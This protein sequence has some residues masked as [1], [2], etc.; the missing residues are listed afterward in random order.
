MVNR[1]HN[2][3]DLMIGCSGWSYRRWVGPFYPLLSGPEEWLSLY[4]KVFPV[5]EIDSTFYGFPDHETIKRWRSSVSDK[6]KFFPKTPKQIT[7][8]NRS[9]G[10]GVLLNSF[11]ESVSVLGSKLGTV[12]IQFPHSFT[13]TSGKE[14]LKSL[15]EELP[16]G[17]RY[18][19]EFRHNSWFQEYTYSTLRN[20]EVA[21]VWSEIPYAKVPAA[22]TTDMI[23]LRLVG[24]RSII[25][26]KIGTLQKDRS[27]EIMKWATEIKKNQDLVN[28]TAIFSNNHFQGFGPATVNLIRE[29]LGL[30]AVDWFSSM[31]SAANWRQDTLF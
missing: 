26:S 15:L 7:H 12:L 16:S 3:T 28:E 8:E 23:Y 31:Q 6:F 2:L 5:V 19:I 9:D 25:D 30:D 24:D 29:A 14:W 20:H 17:F 10:S 11:I 22:L 27:K 1:F 4:S 21:L 18:A 13:Y